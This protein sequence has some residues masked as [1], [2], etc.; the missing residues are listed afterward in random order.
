LDNNW[1]GIID[2]SLYEHEGKCV[3]SES[4]CFIWTSYYRTIDWAFKGVQ[5]HFCSNIQKFE[6]GIPLEIVQHR[7]KFDTTIPHV[8][9]VKY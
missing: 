7:I 9:Q 8:H 4:E 6:K 2:Q 5:R 1:G 3:T